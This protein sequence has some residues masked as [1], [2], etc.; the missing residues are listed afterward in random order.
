MKIITIVGARPQFIKA[1]AVSR[2]IS[3]HNKGAAGKDG[4]INEIIV[5]TGQHY[6]YNMS[7]VFFQEL[8]IPQ[9]DINISVGSGSHGLQTGQMLIKIEEI[10][11]SEKPDWVLVYGDTNSTLAGA[12]AAAKLHITVAH[13]EAGLRS[14]NRIM[15]EEHNRRLTD[16]CSNLLLCP[17]RT[18]VD[19][20]EKEGITKGV[21]WV[22]DVMY[23]SVLY[24]LELAKK[25]SKI[26]EALNLE[27]NRYALATVHRAENT[28]NPKRLKSIFN[29]LDEISA[30]HL[31]V[32]M[33]LHP[34]TRKILKT[35]DLKPTAIKIC[36][37]VSY[38]DM[39]S[40][41][42]NAKMIFTDSGGVQKEAYWMKV[43]CITM[44]DETEWIETVEL[45][46]NVLAGASRYKIV[47]STQL[48]SR[49]SNNANIFGDGKT[50]EKV[51][52]ILLAH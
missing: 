24:N 10:L 21:H 17:T 20:L 5:H 36:D 29:A 19:N 3:E 51:V 35:A 39:L 18:A 41:E 43:P 2:I 45:G 8:E 40:L 25:K 30:N 13:V 27:P 22:G 42:K 1:S 28:D 32:V 23:D 52:S 34:R 4:K 7:Q 38:L 26:I 33:P 12:I 48:E 14:F 49:P 6:D 15:P 46:W 37:P 11:Q 9:P 44:R 31:Q 47:K 50:A 16:H